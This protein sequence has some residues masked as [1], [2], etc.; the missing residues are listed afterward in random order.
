[1]PLYRLLLYI[2][3]MDQIFMYHIRSCELAGRMLGF[4]T[5][6]FSNSKAVAAHLENR[7]DY[8]LLSLASLFTLGSNSVQPLSHYTQLHQKN[9]LRFSF[10]NSWDDI[11]Q[12][13]GQFLEN[14]IPVFKKNIQNFALHYLSLWHTVAAI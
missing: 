5:N 4:Q 9:V 10:S 11:L 7:M 6:G 2:S 8:D 13:N 12:V 1:M 3:Q 14:N